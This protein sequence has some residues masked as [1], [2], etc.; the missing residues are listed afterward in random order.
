MAVAGG[1]F[2]LPMAAMRASGRGLGADRP[3]HDGPLALSR[4]SP[5]TDPL[6]AGHRA[7]HREEVRRWLRARRSL[8]TAVRA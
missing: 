7:H 5:L 8:T 2:G 1:S 6:P 3:A 4:P